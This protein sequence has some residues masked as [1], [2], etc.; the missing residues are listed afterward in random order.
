[1]EE[2]SFDPTRRL[3]PDGACVGVI[4]SDGLCSVCGRTEN[5]AARGDDISESTDEERADAAPSGEAPDSPSASRPAFT[6]S[7]SGFDA[8]RRLCDDGSCVGLV[9]AG[10]RCGVCGRKAE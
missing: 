8:K 5:A 3:C 7:A 1:M 10:G 2:T 4:G 6:A 9:G